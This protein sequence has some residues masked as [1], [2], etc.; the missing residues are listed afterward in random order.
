[1]TTTM[2]TTNPTPT[3]D[4]PTPTFRL[5]IHHDDYPHDAPG[6][7]DDFWTFHSFN[8]S[9]T[10]FTDPDTALS[11]VHCGG[12]RDE[13]NHTDVPQ[14]NNGD[15]LYADWAEEYRRDNPE[16][17][18][19][20]K[21]P[22]G[23]PLS[24][25]EHGNCRWGLEGSMSSTPDFRW[26]GVRFAGFLEVSP[27]ADGAGNREWW[28]GMT[29]PEREKVAESFLEEYTAWCNGEIYGYVLEELS[30]EVCN[31]GFTHEHAPTNEDSCWGFIGFDYFQEEVR[32]ATTAMGATEDNTEVVDKAY[33]M[34][35]YGSFF[36]KVEAKEG[37][38]K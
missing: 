11:C 1:M 35:D 19:E 18:H 14:E 12:K 34:A 13:Y 37:T 33:G 30:P 28:D 23:F 36:A 10:S 5:T 38:T 15:F 6:S 2:T 29:Q 21:G 3:E 16:D 20:Y 27:D 17:L 9:H 4:D 25:F 22:E 26:D 31:L 7:E 32:A 8:S 24:Y